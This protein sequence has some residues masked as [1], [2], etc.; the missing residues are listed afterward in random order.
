M[1]TF[2]QIKNPVI[3]ILINDFLLNINLFCKKKGLDEKLLL[4]V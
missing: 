2:V 3:C 4:R 1:K